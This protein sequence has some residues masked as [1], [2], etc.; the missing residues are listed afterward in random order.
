MNIPKVTVIM[1]AYNEELYI[2]EA[3]DSVLNQTY[4]NFELFVV[5]DGS[6]DRTAEIVRNY[7]DPR[8]RLI[9]NPENIGLPR[10]RNVALDQVQTEFVALLDADDISL[11]HRLKRQVEIFEKSPDL[12]LLGGNA[13]VIDKYGE[14]LG[15]PIRKWSGR[16]T[17][18]T[19]LFFYNAFIN[20]TA[21]FR[22]QVYRE[23]GG[24]Q[25]YAIAEDFEFF[26]R[27]ARCYPV[28]NL[29]EF[30]IK[31]RV[32][33]NNMTVTKAGNLVGC[34]KGIGRLQLEQLNL[35]AEDGY[36][37]ML[38]FAREDRF[39]IPEILKFYV[40]LKDAN[41]RLGIYPRYKFREILFEEWYRV[42][43]KKKTSILH[44]LQLFFQK[45][46]FQWGVFRKK[47]M[48]KMMNF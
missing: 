38:Y 8:V 39:R 41:D 48:K 34:L 11:P 1:P 13:Y 25:N 33:G 23:M 17:V 9:N 12:A 31:Y 4:S 15:E 2:G 10:S 16:D 18:R 27:I 44:F 46:L 47:F 32:H 42:S 22:T 26:A 40:S 45:D 24:Y 3:I 7:R 19:R 30:L 6:T 20:S 35:E 37:E 5:N 43:W 36:A 29:N 28:D 21:M 14:K